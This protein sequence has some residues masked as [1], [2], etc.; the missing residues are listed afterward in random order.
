MHTLDKVKLWDT[1]HPVYEFQLQ[2]FKKVNI[3]D[4][5]WTHSRN[6]LNQISCMVHSKNLPL[7]FLSFIVLS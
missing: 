5:T 1:F 6:R 2:K 7:D 4:L 3:S